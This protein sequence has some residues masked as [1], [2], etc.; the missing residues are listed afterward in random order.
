MFTRVYSYSFSQI[1][2]FSLRMPLCPHTLWRTGHGP[3]RG[4]EHAGTQPHT[5]VHTRG[6]HTRAHNLYG[7]Q[8]PGT[9][10][11]HPGISPAGRE[12]YQ[13]RSGISP[14]P[15]CPRPPDGDIPGRRGHPGPRWGY[16]RPLGD[17]PGRVSGMSSTS[18][19][20][21]GLW[22]G[23][24]PTGSG[25]FPALRGMP[26][27]RLGRWSAAHATHTCVSHHALKTDSTACKTSSM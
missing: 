26:R 16:P 23:A 20:I 21:P 19:D 5:P 10:P 15:L 12:R 2:I 7:C 3:A 8:F 27:P 1:N 14:R 13:K 18:G 4:L 11:D 22:R 6:R 24:S 17:I 25:I 9:S